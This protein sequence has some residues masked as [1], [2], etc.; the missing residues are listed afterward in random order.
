M[1]PTWQ[2]VASLLITG[3]V[4]LNL[5]MYDKLSFHYIGESLAWHRIALG[6]FLGYAF[7]H[8]ISPT[9]LVGGSIR[10]RVYSSM[11][12]SGMSVTNVVAFN[13]VSIWPGLMFLGSMSFIFKSMSLPDQIELPIPMLS[14]QTL[15]YFL[16]AALVIYFI[17]TFVITGTVQFRGKTYHFPSPK[18]A[19]YQLGISSMDWLLSSA[20]LFLL[21]PPVSEVSYVYFLGIYMVAF[22]VGLMSQVPGGLGI[23]ETIVLFFLYPF[24][25][26][27]E[28]LSALIL[29]RIFYFI[30]PLITA[31]VMLGI[32]EIRKQKSS[33]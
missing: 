31:A 16:F 27:I 9:L 20:V 8:N 30:I 26:P 25:E 22:I 28:I 13:A 15:G 1:L 3:L 23:F 11:G 14:L 19:C 12:I 4:Y 6:A 7:S 2:Y 21:I 10:Y 24:M 32:F 17:L 29:F 33:D 18:I 5:T